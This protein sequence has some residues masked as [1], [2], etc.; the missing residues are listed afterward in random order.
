MF[1]KELGS[2]RAAG[3][4]AALG[5][6]PE[7]VARIQGSG[8]YPGLVGNV[9]FRKAAGGVLVISEIFGLPGKPEKC[10]GEVF[11][12]HIHDG[13]QCSGNKEEPFADAGAHYNPENCPHPAHAGDMPPL[14]GNGGYAFQI[15]FTDRF[16]VEEIIGKTVVVHAGP[17]DFTTQ[18]A[19]NAGARIACGEIEVYGG[20]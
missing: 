14:F 20:A 7:A 12:F 9:W 4:A 11:A 10:A 1:G 16:S 3:L 19:G 17:D 8:A 15:F 2:D 6:R 5:Q 13:G 18:P